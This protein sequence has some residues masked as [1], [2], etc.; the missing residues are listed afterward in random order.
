M[1]MLISKESCRRFEARGP[2]GDALT[3]AAVARKYRATCNRIARRL[4]YYPA[5]VTM[6]AAYAAAMYWV[7]PMSC[8]AR[9]RQLVA[10][11]MAA[12]ATDVFSRGE[13]P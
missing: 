13:T 1:L 6:A 2:E 11:A 9:T 8:P 7:G 3:A 10:M 5:G 12:R 4:G